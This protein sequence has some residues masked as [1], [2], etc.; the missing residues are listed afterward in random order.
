MPP[1]PNDQSPLRHQLETYKMKSKIL[2][3]LL[4]ISSLFGF[5]EWGQNKKIFLFQIETEIFSKILKDPLSLTHPFIL[6]PLIGQVLLFLTFI[7]HNPSKIM[8][9]IGMGGIGILMA[10]VFLVGCLNFNLMII[11][12]TIPFLSI[13]FFTI[14]HHRKEIPPQKQI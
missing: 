5:L 13:S 11:L 14:K 3:T 1:V 7:Q 9:Y 4:I 10:L 8:T 6:I 12:S 2:N